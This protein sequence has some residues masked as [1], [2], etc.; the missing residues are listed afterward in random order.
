MIQQTLSLGEQ[1]DSNTAL[2]C[3]LSVNIKDAQ[4]LTST[5]LP[6]KA[7]QTFISMSDLLSLKEAS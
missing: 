4:N 3:T 5:E 6:L 7:I 2:Y 1:L